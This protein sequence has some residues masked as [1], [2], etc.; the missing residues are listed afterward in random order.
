MWALPRCLPTRGYSRAWPGSRSGLRWCCTR[1]WR[2][3]VSFVSCG[4]VQRRQTLGNELIGSRSMT[5]IQKTLYL[6][7]TALVVALATTANVQAWGCA[8]RGYTH[9]G[10]GGVTHVGGTAYR[11]A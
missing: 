9:V 5:V 4:C 7:V 1:D 3:G 8:H 2:F 10:A 11:G 6:A